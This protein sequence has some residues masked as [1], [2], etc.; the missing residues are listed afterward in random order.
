MELARCCPGTGGSEW[1]SGAPLRAV[2]GAEPAP[3]AQQKTP[4]KPGEN[5]GS[6]GSERRGSGRSRTDDGGFAIGPRAPESSGETGAPR[7]MY[8]RM[9]PRSRR[10]RPLRGGR[11]MVE[12]AAGGPSRHPRDGRGEPMRC[13]PTRQ[14]SR[15]LAG[16]SARAS[17]SPRVRTP[18]IDRLSPERGRGVTPCPLRCIA[19]R[20]TC[21]LA[22]AAGKGGTGR[23]KNG[24][25]TENPMPTTLVR[26][27][28][29]QKSQMEVQHGL[30][31][32]APPS[33]QQ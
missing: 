15:M 12:P 5:R 13:P 14:R 2:G 19:C 25:F 33:G 18:P 1:H 8:P 20:V 17:T 7:A 29:F 23:L 27:G 16:P 3:P 32:T 21:G 10:P 26:L 28:S 4:A 11:G 6:Q 22:G 9:Y 30:S 24:F 31:R